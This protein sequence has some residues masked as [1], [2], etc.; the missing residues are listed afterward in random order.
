MYIHVHTYIHIYTQ[1]CNNI[2]SCIQTHACTHTYTNAYTQHIHNV[3]HY[4][5]IIL[6][7]TLAVLYKVLRF[8]GTSHTPNVQWPYVASGHI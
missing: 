5:Q 1:R 2:H 7:R 4:S 8:G 6:S 3:K